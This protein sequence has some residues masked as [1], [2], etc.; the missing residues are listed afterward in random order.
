MSIHGRSNLT[1]DPASDSELLIWL[2]ATDTATTSLQNT[3]GGAIT[4]G[5]TVGQWSSKAGAAR[6]FIQYA[7]N[8]RPT[9]SATGF[10]GRSAVRFNS[11]LLAA[12]VKTGFQSL[13]CIVIMAAAFKTATVGGVGTTFSFTVPHDTGNADTQMAEVSNELWNTGGRRIQTDAFS[14]ANGDS[15]GNNTPFVV[16]GLIE[17]TNAK[18]SLFQNGY[19]R[20]LR[21]S[22]T[23]SA[24]TTKAL[25]PFGIGVGGFPQETAASNGNPMNGYVG[26]VLVKAKTSGIYT[27]DDLFPMHDYICLKW[28]AGAM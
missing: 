7:A 20:V 26:E 8:P 19:E 23:W 25:D 5:A 9:W 2:D 10:N 24:G 18:V 27:P 22:A 6:N 28:G 16:C 11:Q 3:V 13:T 12:D 1:Y 14:G 17:Y 4:D 21:T 15:L